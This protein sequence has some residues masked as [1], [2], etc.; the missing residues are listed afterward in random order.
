M[1]TA[2]MFPKQLY[3]FTLLPTAEEPQRP[4][5]IANTWRGPFHSAFQV[6][7]RRY[8]TAVLM[9]VPLMAADDQRLFV[10]LFACISAY[11]LW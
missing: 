8:F 10:C 7:V 5:A 2:K 4:H 9:C 1:E 11:F 3:H 6:D